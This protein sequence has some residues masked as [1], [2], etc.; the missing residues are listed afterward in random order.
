MNQTVDSIIAVDLC[1]GA[2][3]G[4]KYAEAFK[5]ISYPHDA[6][7]ALDSLPISQAALSGYGLS[8]LDKI[9]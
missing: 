8:T 9:K 5:K 2:E 1:R 4:V 3:A 6:P 7:I